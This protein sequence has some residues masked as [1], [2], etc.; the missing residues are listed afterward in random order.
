MSKRRLVAAVAVM[1]ALFAGASPLAA[2]Q[3]P[4]SKVKIV[5]F[6]GFLG[7]VDGLYELPAGVHD[8]TLAGPSGGLVGVRRLLKK[9]VYKDGLRL[10]T[11]NNMP[12]YAGDSEKP[13]KLPPTSVSHPFWTLLAT[14][15]P[16][17]VAIGAE[18]IAHALSEADG[19]SHLAQLM[20]KPPVP[21]VASNVFIRSKA[22]SM[23]A[24]HQ[25]SYHLEVSADESLDLLR[26]LTVGCDA[27]CASE[28]AAT[29]EDLGLIG[30]PAAAGTMP[31]KASPEADNKHWTIDLKSAPLRPGRQ[32]RL[33]IHGVVFTFQTVAA[34]TPDADGLPVITHADTANSVTYRVL[35]FVQPDVLTQFT[36]QQRQWKRGARNAAPCPAET[37]ELV[38]LSPSA[39]WTSLA[40]RVPHGPSDGVL[41]AMLDLE[42]ETTLELLQLSPAFRVVML[43]PDTTLLGRAAPAE[44]RKDLGGDLGYNAIVDV[45][46]RA[47]FPGLTRV[48]M[49]PEWLGETVH[50]F[51]AA[52]GLVK[53]QSGKD[54]L[55]ALN[56][57]KTEMEFVPGAPLRARLKDGELQYFVTDRPDETGRERDIEVGGRYT[58]YPGYNGKGTIFDGIPIRDLWTNS[59]SMTAFLLYLSLIHI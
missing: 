50:T 37:C 49:R 58:A 22:K 42:D 23:N 59:R 41:T 11:G 47:E 28:E 13:T 44:P 15:A 8:E 12:R 36:P 5:A 3:T 26:R 16:A 54:V 46:S 29:L 38:I 56:N 52:P 7:F 20:Q 21:F 14:L 40:P 6:G 45:A 9:D 10:V 2:R 39:T 31:L 27:T 32:Y 30:R 57:P 48:L 33:S 24:V 43:S 55:M 19:A 1:C 51:Q 53:D 18:D 17:A 4:S 34:L 35:A 25:G